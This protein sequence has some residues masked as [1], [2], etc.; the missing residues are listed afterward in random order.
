ML[1]FAPAAN[2]VLLRPDPQDTLVTT[3][4]YE[5]LCAAVRRQTNPNA[6]VIFWNPRV[7]ALSTSRFAS[8]WPA[9]GKPPEIVHYLQR[10]H[11]SYIVADKS[12]PDDR[13]FLLPVL[14]GS[15][16]PLATVYENNRFRLLRVL[17]PNNA[18]IPE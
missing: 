12:R 13:Q 3:P 7:F 5:Q 9:E 15:T 10:V 18:K 1:L 2:A 11:P 17:P 8:G 6:L 4:Q 16:L 14:A